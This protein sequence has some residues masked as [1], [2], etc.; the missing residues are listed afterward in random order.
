MGGIRG[1]EWWRKAERRRRR[2]MRSLLTTGVSE[3]DSLVSWNVSQGDQT[4]SLL[5]LLVWAGSGRALGG[6]PRPPPAPS[7]ASLGT[8]G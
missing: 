5:G 1:D 3:C 4:A 8:C 7:H 2:R 6:L